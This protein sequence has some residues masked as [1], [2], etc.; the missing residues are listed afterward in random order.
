MPRSRRKLASTLITEDEVMEIAYKYGIRIRPASQRSGENWVDN[1]VAASIELTAL[2]AQRRR[3]QAPF[4]TKGQKWQDSEGKVF[5]VLEV[6][7]VP[8]PDRAIDFPVMV[9]YQAEDGSKW[10][11]TLQYWY[12]S[13]TPI[14]DAG[15]T[16]PHQP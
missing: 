4:P 11:R 14:P 12:A 5:T 15:G 13:M 2:V 1:A 3:Q 7:S 9:I 8:P 16:T 10:P 6:T